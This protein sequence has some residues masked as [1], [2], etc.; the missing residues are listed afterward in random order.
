MTK[1]YVYETSNHTQLGEIEV[2]DA[3]AR[4]T[5]ILLGKIKEKFGNIKGLRISEG[6]LR[7]LKIECGF[8]GLYP[9]GVSPRNMYKSNKQINCS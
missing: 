6:E 1:Y 3:E 2:S 9:K 4:D 8:D 5:D 7:Y